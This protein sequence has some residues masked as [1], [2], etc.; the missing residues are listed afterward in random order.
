MSN[1]PEAIFAAAAVTFLSSA[2]LSS[3]IN[4][5]LK[6]I[7]NAPQISTFHSILGFLVFAG[8]TVLIVKSR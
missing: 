3:T 8:L 4:E 5:F 2:F 7:P 1:T 6:T